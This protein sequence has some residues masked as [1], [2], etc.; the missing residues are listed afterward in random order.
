MNTYISGF[1]SEL[2]AAIKTIRD[3]VDLLFSEYTDA[4]MNWKPAPEKWSMLECIEHLTMTSNQYHPPLRD[5]VARLHR[6]KRL[7]KKPFKASLFANWFIGLLEPGKGMAFKT[8]RSF[9][10]QK[11]RLQKEQVL[12]NFFEK[13]D[14]YESLLSR[15]DGYNLNKPRLKSPVTALIRFSTG[16]TLSLLEAH[17]RRHILQARAVAQMEG[18]PLTV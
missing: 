12:E 5:L 9:A 17:M 7:H 16:E 14:E 4:Q 8:P 18:F 6:E 2:D 1:L 10:P 13:L 11:S 15:A 3:D